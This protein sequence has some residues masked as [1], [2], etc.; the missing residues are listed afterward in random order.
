MPG[1]V[2]VNVG[3]HWGATLTIGQV[4]SLGRLEVTALGDQMNEAARIEEV[5][6][7]GQILASKELLER[8]SPQDADALAL[9]PAHMRFTSLG[10]LGADS[11]SLRDAGSIAVAEI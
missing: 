8:L 3:L 11:K 5:A 9:D 1:E 4:S 7:K 10:A 2:L 6:V